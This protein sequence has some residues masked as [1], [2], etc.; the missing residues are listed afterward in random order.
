MTDQNYSLARGVTLAILLH[1]DGPRV[2]RET[3]AALAA[4][5]DEA[6]PEALDELTID[7]GAIVGNFLAAVLRADLKE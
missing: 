3:G 6:T 2:I 7:A 4:L 1:P 5:S